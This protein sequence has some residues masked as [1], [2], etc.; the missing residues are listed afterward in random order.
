MHHS[1]LK[2]WPPICLKI[3]RLSIFSNRSGPNGGTRQHFSA[4]FAV[5]QNQPRFLA[6][7]NTTEDG[8]GRRLVTAML[9]Q[10]H[11][12]PP[13]LPIGLELNPAIAGWEVN[14]GLFGI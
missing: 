10:G 3:S 9:K 11:K 1:F 4:R 12:P 5:R 13:I 7:W 6:L 14:S 8:R 2:D